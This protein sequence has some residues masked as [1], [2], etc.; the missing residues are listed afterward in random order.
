MIPKLNKLLAENR[1]YVELLPNIVFDTSLQASPMVTSD[2]LGLQMTGLFSPLNQTAFKPADL[3]KNTTNPEVLDESLPLYDPNGLKF[4][5]VLHQM[6][7]TSIMLSYL[8]KNE[9]TTWILSSQVSSDSK[10]NLTTSGLND[11]FVQKV[12][13]A[14]LQEEEPEE[15]KEIKEVKVKNHTLKSKN[16]TKKM[17]AP[18]PVKKK[19]TKTIKHTQPNNTGFVYT[20]GSDKPVDV[21]MRVDGVHNT[22]VKKNNSTMHLNADLSIEYWANNGTQNQ[23]VDLTIKNC[24]F[25]FEIQK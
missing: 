4:Q 13:P 6:S 16:N 5:M 11:V 20:Y 21:K 3:E 19:K 12:D 17:P 23:A 2:F 10:F 7:V 9:L 24:L 1:G 14:R 25:F 15:A 18:T 22:R 8:K